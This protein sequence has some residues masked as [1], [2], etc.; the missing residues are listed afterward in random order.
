MFRPRA[1]SYVYIP[2]YFPPALQADTCLYQDFLH[3]FIFGKP[4]V[5]LPNPFK[6]RLA[7]HN[8]KN[9]SAKPTQF[10]IQM[11]PSYNSLTGLPI[12]CK[13]AGTKALL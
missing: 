11:K 9:T 4:P 3:L 1:D 7:N 5:F 10:K 2:P 8:V 12:Q 6:C 13:E